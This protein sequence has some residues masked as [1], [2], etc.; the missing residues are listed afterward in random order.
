MKKTDWSDANKE[1]QQHTRRHET[2]TQSAV[3]RCK[4]PA[5]AQKIDVFMRVYFPLSLSPCEL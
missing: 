5:Y 1:T 2:S 3:F 4:M